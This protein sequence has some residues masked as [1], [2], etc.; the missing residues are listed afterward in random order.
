VKPYY[1]DGTV[2]I[3]HGDCREI[4]PTLEPVDM[5]VAD[6][7]YNVGKSYGAHDDSMPVDAYQRWCLE[8]F[9]GCRALTRRIVVFPGHG[10]LPVWWQISK[11]SAVGCWYKPGTMA[12]SHIGWSEWEPWLYWGPRASGSSVIRA[13]LGSGQQCDTGDHP[14]PK[15]LK[16]VA[17]LLTKFPGESV[18]DPFLGSGTTL[19][20][21]KNLGRR[22]IGIEIE[23]RYCEI[24]AKRC[25]QDVLDLA[26]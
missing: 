5:I 10:N 8:W 19:R 22:A 17:K 6:P 20:A 12:G 9:G 3:Y 14:C 24:A 18:I 1:D 11:P 23:E 16:L 2:T 4:L 26:A 25:A 13:P 15:P 7:P 21:A